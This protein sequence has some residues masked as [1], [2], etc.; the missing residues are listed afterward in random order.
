[1]RKSSPQTPPEQVARPDSRQSFLTRTFWL[2]IGTAGYILSPLSWWNDLYV[3]IPIAYLA[4][5][6]V[7]RI[8]GALFLSVLTC[9]YWLTNIAGLLLLHVGAKN[10]VTGAIR[11][12]MSRKAALQWLVLSLLYTFVIVLCREIGLIRPLAAYFSHP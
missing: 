8:H 10:A 1:M 11:P 12:A 2:A 4:A 7:A 9:A 5:N 6:L 3:N